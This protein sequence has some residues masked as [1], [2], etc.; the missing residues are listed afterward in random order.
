MPLYPNTKSGKIAFFNSKVTPWQSSATSIGTTAAAVTALLAKIT[1]AQA[2]V[3]AQT[4]AEQAAKTATAAADSAVAEVVSAGADIIKNIRAFAANSANPA[5]VY[6]LAELPAPSTPTP[7]TTLGTPHDFK[8]ELAGDGSLILK[9]KCANPR[10]TGTVYQV[11][12]KLDG[13]AQFSYLGGIGTKSFTDAELPSGTASVLYK[14]QAVRST[15]EGPWATFTVLIG[16][17]ASGQM[18][19]TVAGAPKL[20]A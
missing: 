2:K 18:T 5:N 8:A 12:R 15:A 4:A 7:V 17:G 11:W 16:M 14:V 19:A 9:W 1:A 13:D 10:A 20:A 3:D 6:E